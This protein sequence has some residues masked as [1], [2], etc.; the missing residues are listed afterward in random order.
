[1]DQYFYQFIAYCG[2]F[3]ITIIIVTVC[4]SKI[5]HDIKG[6]S[7][8]EFEAIK[9]IINENKERSL[10]NQEKIKKLLNDKVK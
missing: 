3:S 6:V 7:I 1:M 10:S 4:I 8:E 2:I 5:V 9:K